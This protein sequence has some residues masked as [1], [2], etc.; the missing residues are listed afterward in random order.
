[1]NTLGSV[2]PKSGASQN[3]LRGYWPRFILISA[4]V[5]L[6]CFW[7]RHIEAGDLASHV[8]NAWLAHLIQNGRAPGLYIARQWN[9]VL[10]DFT[11]SGLARILGLRVA[12]RIATS[13]AVLIFFWGAFR[14]VCSVARRLVWSLVPCIAIF[15]YGWTFEEG[16]MN[17]YLSI[18]L[19]FFALALLSSG[20]GWVKSLVVILAGLIWLANPLGLIF[21][22]AAAAYVLLAESLPPGYQGLLFV[23]SAVL[24]VAVHFY[25]GFKIPNGIYDGSRYGIVWRVE[26]WLFL[27]G[28]DQLL[29]YGPKYLLPSYLLQCFIWASILIDLDARRHVPQRRSPAQ[30]YGLVVLAAALLP[31]DIRMPQYSAPLEFLTERLTS[32]AA[33]LACCLMA[34]TRPRKWHFAAF[35]VIAAL[36]FFDLYKDTATISRMEDQVERIVHTIPAG[37]RVVGNISWPG[38]GARVE[39]QHIVDRACIGWCFSYGNYEPS[40]GQ[41]RVRARAGN[42]FVISDSSNIGLVAAGEYRVQKQ[43]LPLYEIYRC[44]SKLCIQEL[45]AGKTN[46]SILPH[47]P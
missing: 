25:I 17:F 28:H 44:D 5:I 23:A 8:Y 41:F 9:N 12:E 22:I 3:S 13:A 1:M 36:F 20:S 31:T 37:E 15:A 34:T 14:L 42:A 45:A 43:D 35:S 47:S 21:L 30:L 19:A 33:I 32:V 46:G 26:S 27:D 24:I 4:V 38:S 6:P 16:L 11:L 39:R 40:T 7:H 29:L 2:L 10:F 18:G